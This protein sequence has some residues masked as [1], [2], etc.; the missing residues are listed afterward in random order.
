[1]PATTRL[2]RKAASPTPKAGK[3]P[4]H[5]ELDEYGRRIVHVPLAPAGVCRI[6]EADYARV[7]A[8]VASPNWQL[9]STGEGSSRY[10]SVR[11]RF[12]DKYV[13]V[14]RLMLD[15]SPHQK[16]KFVGRDRTDLRRSNIR[17]Q[18]TAARGEG[19][20]RRD[21]EHG[22]GWVSIAKAE[23]QGAALT[24]RERLAA[25]KIEAETAD[26]AAA[27]ASS[28]RVARIKAEIE[29]AVAAGGDR[30]A[31]TAAG[32]AQAR[33][34]R[35]AYDEAHGLVDGRHPRPLARAR[36]EKANEAKAARAAG[37]APVGP[38]VLPEETQ[39]ALP[40]R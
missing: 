3:R 1:M 23:P 36:R 17:L 13:A 27:A 20:E 8:L 4:I 6:E 16:V 28:E 2:R 5:V 12:R 10:T 40:F 38:V 18:E 34:E 33:D 11:T 21:R 9:I 31:L 14:A 30:A 22:S 29:A 15:A 39:K 25:E 37:A 19:P 7:V 35:R 24:L 26:K 32:M